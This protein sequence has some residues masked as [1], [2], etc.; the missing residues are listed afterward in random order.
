ME[1]WYREATWV[2]P[3]D[4][5]S[6]DRFES[7][8]HR[9][10]LKS[11][12]GWPYVREAST[13]GMF[14][15]WDGIKFDPYAVDRLWFE[16]LRW[17]EGTDEDL[18]LS[19]FIKLEPHKPSKVEEGRWRLIMAGPLHVQMVWHMLFSYQNDREIEKCYYIPSQQGIVLPGGGWKTYTELWKS[20]G[21][22]T[23]L[24]KSAWDWTAPIWLID[25]DL[26]FRFR[27]GRGK[28]MDAW[29]KVATRA[30]DEMFRNPVIMMPN[31]RCFRQTIPGIMKSG[32][33]NTISSNSHMQVMVHILACIYSGV[34]V[35][36]FP[37]C[38]G[39]DTLQRKQQA[40]DLEAYKRFGAL[41]KSASEGLEFVG[42]EFTSVGP[43]PLY[44]EKH[45]AKC[46]TVKDSELREYL[47]A[48][49]R[50]YCKSNVFDFWS[51]LAEDLGVAVY[52]KE[53][54]NFWYDNE[55]DS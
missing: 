55:T 8:L 38:C 18:I 39:D 52:S 17:M 9:I 25:L 11:S 35:Y 13:N 32:C 24:D 54:Y 22:D 6:R 53:Y 44:L 14:L 46:L 1:E 29:L 10:D 43:V 23:G 31:G 4:W 37:V 48:M 50:M 15:G 42:H 26:R 5:N 12:P 16:V 40:V 36:P 33:V 45:L 34:D 27:M 47:D 28:N 30:Y 49:C 51:W 20:R 41:V 7:L 19:C 2:L 3:D 21:Y